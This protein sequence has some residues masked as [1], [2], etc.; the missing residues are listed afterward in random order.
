VWCGVWYVVVVVAACG[1]RLAALRC[2]VRRQ[3]ADRKSE[4]PA[5]FASS[6][7]L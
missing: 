7:E 4:I 2:A 1:L 3:I 5:R 6:C